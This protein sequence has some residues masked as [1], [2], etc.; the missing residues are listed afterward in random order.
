MSRELGGMT[1]AKRVC[2]AFAIGCPRNQADTAWLTSYFRANGWAVVQQARNADMVVVSTC[3]FTE[4]VEKESVRLVSLLH[5]KR[6]KE[7]KLIVVGCL[8]GINPDRVTQPFDAMAI[9]PADIHHLDQ[10]IEATVP[11][12]DV[13]PVN[14]VEPRVFTAKTC[15]PIREADPGLPPLAAVKCQ[16]KRAVFWLLSRVG[17]DRL[18]MR[19]ARRLSR[20][21]LG[22]PADPTFY[23]RVARG[24]LEECTY[25]AIRHATGTLRSKPL[26]KVLAEFD[27]GLAQK[28]TSFEILAEDIGSYGLDIGISCVE[29]F[30]NLFARKGQYKLVL[31]DVNVRYLI[32]YTPVLS[33]ILATHADRIRWL[34]VPVQ[35]GS[36]KILR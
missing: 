27:L 21:P 36:D 14:C 5:E 26:D 7:S 32:R 29:L 20:R 11:L 2:I 9:R 6:R 15:W 10:L 25:C 4:D 24:C 31:T 28:H 12:Q 33:D 19:T 1:E 8:A 13:P 18:A 17:T 23:I 16:T 35:S 22:E 30:E 34:K 3:G